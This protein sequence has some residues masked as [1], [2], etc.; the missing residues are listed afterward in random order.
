MLGIIAHAM[1]VADAAPTAEIVN[2]KVVAMP[3]PEVAGAKGLVQAASLSTMISHQL[4]CFAADGEGA[5]AA[6]APAPA[7]VPK[8]APTPT[9]NEATALQLIVQAAS[10][11]TMISHQVPCFVAAGGEEAAA[12]S[13]PAPVSKPTTNEATGAQLVVQATLLSTMISH[14]LPCFVAAP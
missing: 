11:S 10:L 4:P 3:K 7:P 5:A 2:G 13:T 6:P 12:A 8:P 14:Q 1:S 9:T